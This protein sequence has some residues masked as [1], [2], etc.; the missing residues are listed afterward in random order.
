MANLFVLTVALGV[1][2]LAIGL[3]LLRRHLA[4]LMPDAASVLQCALAFN[5]TFFWQELWLVIPKALTPG[6]HPILFHNNHDWTG[7]SGLTE[8][9]QGSGAIATLISGLAF[10]AVLTL[11]KRASP[12]WRSFFFWMAFQGLYQSLIQLAIGA[13]LPGNDMGRALV[14]L[15]LSE[16]AKMA[17]LALAGLAMPFAGLWLARRFPGAIGA[18]IFS[19][20]LSVIVIVPFRVPRN[21]IEVALV[22]LIINVIGTG[23]LVLGAGMAGRNESATARDNILGPA[24]ALCA[25][26]LFFQLVLR[27]GIAF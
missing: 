4:P 12:S 21:V 19:G 22:P 7:A 23:W 15:G 13:L 1:V 20:L 18:M 24:L 3:V 16:T 27:P 17:L 5:L 10:C 11:A 8:L 26:L 14:Y 9:L 25:T 2:P 6:L